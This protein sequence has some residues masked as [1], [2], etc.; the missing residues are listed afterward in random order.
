MIKLA[1]SLLFFGFLLI[2]LPFVATLEQK[3]SKIAHKKPLK[4]TKPCYYV[5]VQNLNL[6]EAP[7][8]DSTILK[9]LPLNSQIC[10]Y[11]SL[12]NDF[13]KTQEG[14]VYFEY[15]S[16]FPL[17]DSKK[18]Q[19]T[20]PNITLKSYKKE[21]DWFKKAEIALKSRDY[22]LAK[23]LAYKQ[24]L[25]NP[26]DFRSYEI[27]AK[28]LYEEGDKEEAKK[29]LENVL[30]YEFDEKLQTLLNSFQEVI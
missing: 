5:K 28:T 12:E 17:K 7:S 26:L 18:E 4:I 15:L 23:S 2:I 3:S 13:L 21:M 1:L 8:L 9:Q 19:K 6:R 29:L 11:E 20:S 25:K 24:N 22:K 14:Y 10:K 30:S 27:Y 16:L